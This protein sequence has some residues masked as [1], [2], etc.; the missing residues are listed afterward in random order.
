MAQDAHTA[1]IHLGHQN[2]T[3]TLWTPNR[4]EPAV[5]LLAHVG[6]V[7]S[8]SVDPGSA[9]RYVATAGVDGAV[10]V[11][12][13]RNWRG[14]VRTWAARGGAAEVEWSQRGFLAVA[15][16]G[17]VNVRHLPHSCSPLLCP[18]VTY[19]SRR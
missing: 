3:L 1:V 5:R 13:C 16:G 11:W 6:P 7:C 18:C 14:A 10:K 17:T 12:D 19:P 8:V 4:A 9:G 15:S 2:G